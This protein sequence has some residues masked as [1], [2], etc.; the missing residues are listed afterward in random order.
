MN[1]TIVLFL[2][3]FSWVTSAQ[4]LN[5]Q[6]EIVDVKSYSFYIQIAD[7]TDAIIV[8]AKTSILL[9]KK[10][11]SIFLQLKN[12]NENGKGMYISSINNKFKKSVRFDHRNDKITIYNPGNWEAN[13]LLEFE[14]NYTGIPQDGLYIKTSMYGKKTFFGDNWPNRAHHWLSVIDHPSDKAVVAFYIKAPK[15]YEVIAS[16]ALVY[17]DT[18]AGIENL[19]H[20]KT[21]KELPTKVMVFGAADFKIKE[22][23]TIND[24]IVSSWIYKEA[25]EAGFED[26]KPAVAVLKYYD[27]IIGTY[28]YEKLANVQSKTR[29]GGMENAGNIFYY[30]E[31]VNGKHQVE[32][33]VA[34]EVAHQWFGNSVS[35]ENWR[36]IWLS[37]GFATYLTD[38]YLEYK[39][40]KEKLQERMKMERDKVIRY[41]KNLQVQPIVYDEKDNLFKLLNRNSYEKGAWVLHMLRHKIGD[42]D[43]FKVLKTYYTKFKNKNAT[44]D[45]FIKIVESITKENL[46]TFFNQWLY[47]ATIPKLKIDW[48]IEKDVLQVDIQQGKE[49]FIFD[50]PIKVID[51]DTAHFFNLSIKKEQQHFD[52]PI[53]LNS[54]SAKIQIDPNVQVLFQE[55]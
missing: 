33:L 2:L 10:V 31:S 27:S 23:D 12:I 55:E 9:K 1:K 50:L 24:I 11:D 44:T 41:N 29:F 30:E 37:E 7:T 21:K 20:Y 18:L 3:C 51:G 49:L 39:Y 4:F 6:K 53:N 17:K 34:H 32:A 25:P 46:S 13:D 36:D 38:L 16:G 5:V 48:I 54:K 35:E 45:D 28:P 26:Y 22:L 52:F 43:F 14:I 47:R 19:Y 8:K 42:K 40:G 15:H